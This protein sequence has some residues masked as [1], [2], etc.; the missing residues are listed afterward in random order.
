MEFIALTLKWEEWKDIKNLTACK[1][2]Q[3]LKIWMWLILRMKPFEF[4]VI[5]KWEQ[6]WKNELLNF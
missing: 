2:T 3:F 1:W 4:Y 5:E 6:F